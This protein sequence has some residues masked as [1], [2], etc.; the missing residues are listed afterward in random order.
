MEEGLNFHYDAE[1]DILD[2]SVGKPRKALS[3]EVG[4]DVL[5][6]VDPNTKKIIGFTI[7][8][9]RK[10]FQASAEKEFRVPVK[11]DFLPA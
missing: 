6:R 11:A 7:L 8:N 10:H 3:V 4:N 5:E 2:I 1:G 9:F